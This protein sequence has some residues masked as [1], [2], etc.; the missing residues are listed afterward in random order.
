VITIWARFHITITATF[1]A[2]L[3]FQSIGNT[4]NIIFLGSGNCLTHEKCPVRNY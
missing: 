4:Q 1:I 3:Q 2:G